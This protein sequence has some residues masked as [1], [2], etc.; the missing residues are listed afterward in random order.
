MI[1]AGA[2]TALG[3]VKEDKPLANCYI[4]IAGLI[5]AGKSTLTKN[6]AEY[7]QVPSY[8]ESVSDNVYLEDFYSDMK[9]YSFQLQ[10]YNLYR[11]FEQQQKIAWN[12]NGGVQDRSIYEDSIFA[13]MLCQSG[14]LDERDYETYINLFSSM[15]SFMRKPDVIVYLDVTPQEALERIKLRNRECEAGIT[16][17]YLTALH[18][19]YQEFLQN[20]S[21]VIPVLRVDWK[22][23]QKVEDVAAAIEESYR[24]VS[25]IKNVNFS[26]K[27]VQ[28]EL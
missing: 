19:A 26:P 27:Q 4:A 8:F 11:R 22:K 9:T 18:E 13:K 2:H 3:L 15:A 14:L 12:G 20:I 16:I 25:N 5:G 24:S 17:E 7:I 10:I 6:L 21:R 28:Q 23:F 1:S